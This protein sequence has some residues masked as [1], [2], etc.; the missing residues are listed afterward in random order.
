MATKRTKKES[1]PAPVGRIFFGGQLY[2]ECSYDSSGKAAV[3]YHD[4]AMTDRFEK[5]LT[6]RLTDSVR[7]IVA[8]NPDT[9]L[10]KI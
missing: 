5:T 9:G 7:T 1:K 3:V 4:D 10:L 8:E 2:H 6:E